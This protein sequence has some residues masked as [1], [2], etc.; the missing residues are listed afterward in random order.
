MVI[1]LAN[2]NSSHTQKWVNSVSSNQEVMLI[3]HPLS[4]KRAAG[5]SKSVKFVNI[6]QAI[7]FALSSKG[8][9]VVH[10]H[11][12]GWL[13]LLALLFLHD[14]K[15]RVVITPWGSDVKLVPRHSLKVHWIRYLLKNANLV[16]CD[17]NELVKC[18]EYLGCTIRAY[19]IIMFGVDTDAYRK[20]ISSADNINQRVC[21]GSNRSHWPVY[22]VITLLRAAR[23]LLTK[24]KSL[25]CRFVI[26]GM[27]GSET[28]VLKDYTVK[29][30]LQSFVEFVPAYEPD[31]VLEFYKSIDIYV[32]CSLSDGGLS[33]STAEAMSCGLVVL[34]ADNSE[35]RLWIQH[36]V[37]GYLFPNSDCDQLADLL[38]QVIYSYNS[39]IDLR[40][41]A[42]ETIVNRNSLKGEMGKVSQVYHSLMQ[43]SSYSFSTDESEV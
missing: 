23:R 12:V 35:N 17:S 42:R 31:R 43:C 7:L 1:F 18:L 21:I 25:N 34:S 36:G 27:E 28:S 38:G 11:Y 32:S 40:K 29:Y 14:K 41:N 26:S 22:D 37:N 39:H 5:Y 2:G 19:K 15:S 33:S 8:S 20:P 6:F 3:T 24:E 4:Q 16:M 13:S 30:G 9:Y 10:V